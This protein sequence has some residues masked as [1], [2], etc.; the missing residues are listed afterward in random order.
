MNAVLFCDQIDDAFYAY[1]AW[2]KMRLAQSLS[3]D[4]DMDNTYEFAVEARA[5]EPLKIVPAHMARHALSS[6]L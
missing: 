1:R 5:A 2:L 3:K 6:E 4:K